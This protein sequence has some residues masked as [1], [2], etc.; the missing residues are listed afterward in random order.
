VRYDGG[1]R[2]EVAANL[3]KTGDAPSKGACTKS[4]KR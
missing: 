4:A 1:S 3:L 2:C